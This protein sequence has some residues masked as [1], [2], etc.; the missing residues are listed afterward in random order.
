[1]LLTIDFWNM[2]INRKRNGTFR[3]ASYSQFVRKLLV[4]NPLAYT[5][6][7]LKERYIN[8]PEGSFINFQH[9]SIWVENDALNVI[10]SFVYLSIVWDTSLESF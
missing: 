7:K 8:Q 9:V 2:K 3:E 10:V 1:M 4:S 5:N 6:E